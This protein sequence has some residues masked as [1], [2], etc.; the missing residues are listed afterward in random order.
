MSTVLARTVAATPERT[1]SATWAKI[2]EILAPDQGCEARAELER[3]KGVVM[4]SIASEATRD[5]AIVVHSGGLR[6]RIYCVFGDDAING[7]QVNEEPLTRSPFGDGWQIS[8]PCLA[9]DVG[10]SQRQ[11]HATSTRATARAVG[12]G[13]EEREPSQPEVTG[14]AQIDLEEF[15]RP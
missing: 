1:A 2:V 6:V 8:I 13:V 9:E 5:D 12:E 11:L 15:N 7:D 14:D 10:W 4:A 3:V